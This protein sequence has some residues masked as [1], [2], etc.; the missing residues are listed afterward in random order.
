MF[1]MPT[2]SLPLNRQQLD[3]LSRFKNGLK[4]EEIRKDI[5]N[6]VLPENV[7]KTITNLIN[8]SLV[9][10]SSL[11]MKLDYS[12]KL[13]DL[14]AFLKSHNQKVSGRKA[15]LISLSL[16][17]SN[18]SFVKKIEK[19]KIF[20]LTP[21][22]EETVARYFEFITNERNNAEEK[23]IQY[24]EKQEFTLAVQ[25]MVDFESK[26]VFP[27]GMGI[28]WNKYNINSDINSLK[29]IFSQFPKYLKNIEIDKR[30]PL[31][32]AGAMSYLWG[33][34]N[35]TKWLPEGFITNSPIGNDVAVNAITLRLYSYRS[36]EQYKSSGVLDG[37]SI[38]ACKDSCEEC[39]K[40]EGKVFKLDN[41]PELP[42]EN[43]KCLKGCRCCY[44]PRVQGVK[45]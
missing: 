8:R 29:F 23:V 35:G 7:D 18:D 42:Y 41:A 20:G 40:L 31:L 15:E 30:K 33:T 2:D 28:N 14:K 37:V 16:Q 11:A 45:Y 27:R 12:Y 34:G 38:L 43:C 10:E 44:L 19:Q 3:F 25:T 17:F 36:M 32:I 24:L 21:F 13:T 1:K 26:Q 9:Q 5:W 39:K 22:G 6:E 4:F